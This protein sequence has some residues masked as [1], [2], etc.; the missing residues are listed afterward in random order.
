MVNLFASAIAILS[1]LAVPTSGS[2]AE[3]SSNDLWKITPWEAVEYL[4]ND[5]LPRCTTTWGKMNGKAVSTTDGQQKLHDSIFLLSGLTGIESKALEYGPGGW[6]ADRR[7]LGEELDKWKRALAREDIGFL[8]V[9][10]RTFTT[11]KGEEI[12]APDYTQLRAAHRGLNLLMFGKVEKIPEVLCPWISTE[13]STDRTKFTLLLQLPRTVRAEP[14][15]VV[16]S[17]RPHDL[18]RDDGV[19]FFLFSQAQCSEIFA[20]LSRAKIP[21]PILAGALAGYYLARNPSS[22]DCHECANTTD[23]LFCRYCIE[24]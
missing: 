19:P 6:W 1:L 12:T 11:D 21:A 3:A 10:K 22:P 4:Q 16:L 2:A 9:Q 14:V 15:K 8:P 7:L 13:G 23:G 5:Y 24:E 18:T 17:G 20:V